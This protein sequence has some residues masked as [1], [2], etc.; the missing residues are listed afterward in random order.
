M[1]SIKK[2]VKFGIVG[3]GQCGGNLAMEFYKKGYDALFL[4]TSQTDLRSLSVPEEAKLYIGLFQKDG[5]GQ[6][7]SIGEKSVTENAPKIVNLIKDRF[8]GVDHLLLT[9]GLGGGT[10]SN[11]SALSSI[12]QNQDKP[13]S[14]LLT[15]PRDSEGS[16]T[17]VNAVKAVDEIQD[18][19]AI[20]YM[21]I[22]NQKIFDILF[23]VDIAS[24]Y[25]KANQSVINVFDE[26]N[27]I[28]HNSELHSLRSFD[29]EDLRKVFNFP[30]VLS[31]GFSTLKFDDL[32]GEDSLSSA[33]LN[34][35]NA[36][37]ILASGFDYTNA[38]I[39]AMIL[40]APKKILEL[41]PASIHEN[42]ISTAGKLAGGSAIYTGLF[43]VPE[44]DSIRFYTLCGGLPLPSR[45][46]TLL[47]QAKNEGMELGKK[48]GKKTSFMDLGE[49]KSINFFQSESFD[50]DAWPDIGKKTKNIKNKNIKKI[51]KILPDEKKKSK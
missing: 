18:S 11:V 16:I 19:G 45:L 51:S 34:Q 46:N 33:L 3:L 37:G 7:T 29:S 35:F 50:A 43:Q 32:K 40:I 2:S 22:D 13:V 17:K 20:S 48:L 49:I 36:G 21:F 42:L 26:I 8:A 30:G 6:D 23:D 9:A 12:L 27:C 47:E 14:M 24:F 44:G 10:G 28:S 5:A 38:T 15:L 39:T 1:E 4:N 31:Y 41:S 25:S